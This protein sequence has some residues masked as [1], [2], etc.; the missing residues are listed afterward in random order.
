MPET[1]NIK[2]QTP[3]TLDTNETPEPPTPKPSVYAQLAAMLIASLNQF[4]AAIPEFNNPQGV[5][6]DFVKR[7]RRVPPPFV[8]NA[9]SALVVEQ[10]L[11][12]IPQLRPDQVL[13]DREYLDTLKPVLRHMITAVKGLKFTIDVREAR[14]AA[15]AQQIYGIA[16]SLAADRDAT[17]IAAHVD[18]MKKARRPSKRRKPDV[19]E[20][21]AKE[22]TDTDKS[23]K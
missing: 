7:K 16:R 18:N 19:L 5:S 6:K 10:E 20:I 14:L 8:D 2:N 11:Q 4:M 3:P 9:V 13:D 12:G 17:S 15:S 21:K 1:P 23:R 22:G